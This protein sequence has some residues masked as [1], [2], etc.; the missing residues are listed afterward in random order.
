MVPDVPQVPADFREAPL[1]EE[2]DLQAMERE[3][4]LLTMVE[5]ARDD[6]VR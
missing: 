6:H 1:A 5:D 2:V 4:V 3:L